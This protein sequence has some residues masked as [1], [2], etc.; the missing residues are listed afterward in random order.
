M[1][2]LFSHE[3]SISPPSTAFYFNRP[4]N[5][6]VL[7]ISILRVRPESAGVGVKYQNY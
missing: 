6:E 2:S 4:L 3:V 5:L 1:P 7:G